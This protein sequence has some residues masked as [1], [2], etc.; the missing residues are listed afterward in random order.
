MSTS[1]NTDLPHFTP[2]DFSNLQQNENFR[3][4]PNGNKIGHAVIYHQ[5][6]GIYADQYSLPNQKAAAKWH[7]LKNIQQMDRFGQIVYK[8]QTDEP[9]PTTMYGKRYLELKMNGTSLPENETMQ[10]VCFSPTRDD[11]EPFWGSNKPITL[12][13][14]SLDKNEKTDF[15]TESNDIKKIVKGGETLVIQPESVHHRDANKTRTPSQNNVMSESAV[16]AYEGFLDMYRDSL[17]QDFINKLDECI[18]APLRNVFH[19]QKR[20]EWLHAYGFSL[21]P[22]DQN[23]Q[24]RENL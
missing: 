22:V 8:A 16:K 13:N 14:D 5:R 4:L 1:R 7:P 9:V 11:Q 18:K 20:P 6:D 17:S 12:F 24:R 2:Q 3:Y 21:T 19:S 15:N 23:P 10:M